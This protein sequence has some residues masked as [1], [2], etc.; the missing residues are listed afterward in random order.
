MLAVS[1]PHGNNHFSGTLMMFPAEKLNKKPAI[2]DKSTKD[3]CV[4]SS[5]TQRSLFLQE[6][7]FPTSIYSQ[8][9]E[10]SLPGLIMES[11]SFPSFISQEGFEIIT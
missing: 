11:C 7:K 3:M 4:G 8:Q 2:P 5:V 9:I 10:F 6:T 1:V